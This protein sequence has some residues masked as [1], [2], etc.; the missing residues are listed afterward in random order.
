MVTQVN[1]QVN[2]NAYSY[3]AIYRCSIKH[4]HSQGPINDNSIIMTASVII[5]AAFIV[6]NGTA[7]VAAA[8]PHHL[9][10]LLCY[11]TSLSL[12]TYAENINVGLL[13][14]LAEA[15]TDSLHILANSKKSS[16]KVAD[17]QSSCNLTRELAISLAELFKLL[18]EY[19]DDV[20]ISPM[21]WCIDLA[22]VLAFA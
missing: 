9:V 8:G 10:Y 6:M 20:D 21:W 7:R 22:T 18:Y 13:R 16:V 1:D 17:Y 12:K 4:N 2:G 5:T 11:Y 19:I 14:H 15:I 3:A